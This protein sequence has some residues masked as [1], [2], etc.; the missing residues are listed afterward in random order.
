MLIQT[1]NATMQTQ[2]L[3]RTKIATNA[4]PKNIMKI[5]TRYREL[6]IYICM[7]QNKVCSMIYRPTRNQGIPFIKLRKFPPPKK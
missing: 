4:N 3:T 7:C 6:Y 1:E 5:I 2:M